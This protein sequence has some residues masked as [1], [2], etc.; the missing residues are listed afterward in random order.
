MKLEFCTEDGYVA[1]MILK[2]KGHGKFVV[3]NKCD[4]KTKTNYIT[5]VC[6]LLYISIIMPNML[7]IAYDKRNDTQNNV[8]IFI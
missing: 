5:V 3:S 7:V 4:R 1:A 6:P 8:P 2:G